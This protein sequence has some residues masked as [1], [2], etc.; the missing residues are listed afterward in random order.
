MKHNPL[1]KERITE[2][3]REQIYTMRTDS[4]V[5]IAPE[6]ALAEDLG[7]SRVSLKAAIKNLIHEGMLLQ[8]QGKGTYITPT[9]QL[10]TL[11]LI[12]SPDIKSNDPFY[13][14][15]LVEV[16]GL[17]AKK[18]INLFMVDP[19]DFKSSSETS[20]LIVI[21]LLDKKLMDCLKMSYRKIIAIQDYEMT[22]GLLQVYFDDYR[23]GCK[24]AQ[25]F[26]EYH[27]SKVLHLAG[28]EKY[29][30]ASK[31]RAGFLE[32][33]NRLGL[34]PSV[35]VEKMNW[36]GGYHAGEIFLEQFDEWDRYTAVFAANDWMSV[37]FIQKLKEKGVRVPEEI[38]VIGCDDIPLASEFYPPLTTFNLD[39]RYLVE[40]VF[41]SMN[42]FET[43]TD[44]DTRNATNRKILIP[45]KLI[46]RDSLNS[47]RK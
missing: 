19:L 1:I 25:T 17:A 16:T 3:L 30:S 7:V 10:H 27:H 23:I 2:L 26:H 11:H 36:S 43:F 39:M 4:L 38:S 29:P 34:K 32:I 37:G 22:D 14:K 45:A 6:R 42:K 5:R 13:N 24:A 15:F 12:C 35:I 47:L 46:H 8:I 41:S 33:S 21:G 44:R 31:R 20:P 28:P 40:E 9:V 18:C